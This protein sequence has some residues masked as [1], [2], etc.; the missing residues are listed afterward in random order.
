MEDN[1]YIFSSNLIGDDKDD[2]NSQGVSSSMEIGCL[3]S[4]SETFKCRRNLNAVFFHFRFKSTRT[5]IK[6]GIVNEKVTDWKRMRVHRKEK[7]K[8]EKKKGK[9]GNNGKEK[10]KKERREKKRKERKE[11]K[12][13]EKKDKKK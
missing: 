3:N 7:K 8:K 5:A 6:G 4:N 2:R 13:K 10:E 12:R 9:K 11:K 1:I